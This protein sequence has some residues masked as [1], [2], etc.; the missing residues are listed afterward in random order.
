MS[1]LSHLILRLLFFLVLEVIQVHIFSHKLE[2][3]LER[4][5]DIYYI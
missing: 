4:K 3:K 2:A 5:I 1:Y